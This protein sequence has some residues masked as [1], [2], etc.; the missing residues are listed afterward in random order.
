MA[1]LSQAL[2]ITNAALAADQA[3][4]SV[5]AGNT[6]N[7]NTPGFTKESVQFSAVDRVSIH[8][9][10]VV[11][12]V[13][14]TAAASQ[15]DRL[16]NQRIDQQT[17]DSAASTT[18][19]SALQ[20]LQASFSG[21]LNATGSTNSSG[22]GDIGQQLTSFFTS[23]SALAANP[24]NVSLRDG[25][26]AAAQSLAEGFNQASS[27]LNRQR[28]GLDAT[29]G[30]VAEQVNA[31]TSSIA[32][33]NGRI[34]SASPHAD[35]GTLEDQRQ[36][37]LEQLS[38][39]VGVHQISNENNGLTI[40]TTSGAVLV[41]GSTSVALQTQITGGVTT[42]TLGGVDQTTALTEGGGQVG[43]ILQARD[44]DLPFALQA[45]NQLASSVGNAVNA[46]QASGLDEN[47]S[48]GGP[49]FSLAPSV[50]GSAGAIAVVLADPKGVAAAA[51]GAGV[52]DGSNAT[53]LAALSSTGIVSG[54]SPNDSYAGLISHIGSTV[55]DT[56]ALQT[57]QS[58]SLAQLKSQQSAL[59]SVNL[60]DQAALLQSFEQAYQAAAKVFAILNSVIGS[61]LNL[62]V[63]TAFSG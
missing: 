63:Q 4:I 27:S 53:A 16:L 12:G 40:T 48:A 24:A 13:T 42:L 58:A 19:L 35:A 47:G 37:D 21:A 55:N 50:S 32:N 54:Q 8:G 25:V 30:S 36:Y 20:D 52:Q 51:A 61:A 59:S 3:A 15:R 18:R 9:S 56:A 45:L 60:N 49:I 2:S 26:L 41:Q 34:A 57:A 6:A 31:L 22:T 46:R 10:T 11:G 23:F 7:A 62:G 33:L 14:T 39:L 38:Q 44:T 28:A 17:Q 1:S 29:V 5:V 43:G